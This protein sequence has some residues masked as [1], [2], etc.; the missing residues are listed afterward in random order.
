MD[1]PLNLLEQHEILTRL[2]C[3]SCKKGKLDIQAEQ[4]ECR[5]LYSECGRTFSVYKNIPI[6]IN[7]DNSLFDAQEIIRQHKSIQHKRLAL[8]QM[9]R[10]LLPDLV[11]NTITQQKIALF[12]Q[13][14]L[15]TKTEAT[16]LIIGGGV[17]GKG[18]ASLLRNRNIRCIE[19]DIY[20]GPRTN[21]ICDA[22]DLPFD[23]A[24]IDAVLIQAVLEHVLDPQ[25]CVA[26]IHRV[27]TPDGVVYAETPFMQQV[28]M[29]AFD[30]TRFT[31]LGH[32]R[33]FRYFT[34]IDSGPTCG[35]GMA[36][37]WSFK[38]FLASLTS[39]R[40][41]SKL[42][43][44]LAS[45]LIFWV[46][47]FDYFLIRHPG[48]YDAASSFFFLGRKATYPLEDGELI[49]LYRGLT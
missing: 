45:Y 28:H 16:V 27:L 12:Q 33:L 21:L 42:L 18:I 32:R 7:P 46:V 23:D 40:K 30:Y 15:K 49:Q 37:A 1:A 2:R 6:L 38:Y 3:P 22:H 31:H 24:S 9:L 41:L 29:G 47:Y 17:E 36:L 26:E 10:K 8:K 44:V 5:C 14:I 4:A 25:R 11:L 43:G 13:E 39:N 20:I 19:S 48:S 34:E 35:P